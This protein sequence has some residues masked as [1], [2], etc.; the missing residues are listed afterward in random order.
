M[1]SNKEKVIAVLT[2]VLAAGGQIN[3]SLFGIDLFGMS[4]DKWSILLFA[5]AA[6]VAFIILRRTGR[7]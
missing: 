3:A 2:L 1:L 4:A 6:I 7:W 5:P